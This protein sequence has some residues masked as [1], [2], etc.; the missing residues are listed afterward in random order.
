M[1]SKAD[2][3][4]SVGVELDEGV[5]AGAVADVEPDTGAAAE[6]PVVDPGEDGPAG[7]DAIADPGSGVL[8]EP[9]ALFELIG[10]VDADA[11]ADVLLDDAAD[12]DAEEDAEAGEEAD[13]VADPAGSTVVAALATGAEPELCVAV[14]PG[15]GRTDVMRFSSRGPAALPNTRVN[16]SSL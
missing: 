11:V 9:G 12:E 4:S 2:S 13:A 3:L 7:L 6:A 16:A 5:V 14:A 8:A 10:E 15:T 1:A